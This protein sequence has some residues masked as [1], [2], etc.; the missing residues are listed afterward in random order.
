MGNDGLELYNGMLRRLRSEALTS[1]RHTQLISNSLDKYIS[2]QTQGSLIL[3]FQLS[4]K[5]RI[6]HCQDG[7][8]A[9]SHQDCFPLY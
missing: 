2:I 8:F 7:H 4:I 5:F 1:K 6:L 3:E 9:W